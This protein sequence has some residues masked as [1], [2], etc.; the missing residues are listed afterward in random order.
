MPFA[1]E[2]TASAVRDLE[3]ICDGLAMRRG[4]DDAAALLDTFIAT[5]ETLEIY[6]NRG[7][8]PRELGGV[9]ITDFRQLN[10]DQ[11]RVIYRVLG[12]TVYI[13]LIADGRRDMQS[14]LQQRLLSR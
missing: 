13:M 4:A 2:L 10:M 5:I 1:V 6:P 3:E 14:L 7:A 8:I 11:F 9:G 12:Q